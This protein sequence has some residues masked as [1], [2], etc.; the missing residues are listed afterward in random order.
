MNIDEHL[1]LSVLSAPVASYDRR[2]LSQAWYSALYGAHERPQSAGAAQISNA[3]PPRPKRAQGAET[4]LGSSRRSTSPSLPSARAATRINAN[5]IAKGEML[6]RR[7][8]R[9]ALAKAIEKTFSSRS[10]LPRKAAFTVDG[11]SGRVQILLRAGSG[12]IDLVAIC[13]PRAAGQVA[14]ALAQARYALSRSGIHLNV[15]TRVHTAC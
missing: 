11:Q 10:A 1:G 13:A 3:T 14:A 4:P 5:A 9:L 15:A 8:P 6:D 2:A 7:S 12:R